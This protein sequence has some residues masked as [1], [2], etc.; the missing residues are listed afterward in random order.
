[1][2]SS[3][4]ARNLTPLCAST[5]IMHM[6]RASLDAA[7]LTHELSSRVRHAC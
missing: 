7:L 1:M 2:Q 3:I 4:F 5:L 6:S